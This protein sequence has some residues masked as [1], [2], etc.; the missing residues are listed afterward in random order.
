MQ[1]QLS[2][3]STDSSFYRWRKRGS[4]KFTDF[5]AFK[6]LA[7]GIPG[8]SKS[9]LPMGTP[10][11]IFPQYYLHLALSFWNLAQGKSHSLKRAFHY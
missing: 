11:K 7:R 3:P 1:S 8:V 10:G 6:D 4:I 9:L 5:A 2:L